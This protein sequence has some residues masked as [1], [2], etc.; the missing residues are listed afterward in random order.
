MNMIFLLAVS[1]G[2]SICTALAIYRLFFSPLA[3]IPGPK[4]AAITAWYEF[5]WDCVQQGHYLFKIGQMHQKY[6]PIVRINPW[7]VHIQDPSY[8]DTIYTNNKIDKDAWFYR[9][10]GDNRGTVGTGPWDLHRRR[11]AAMAKFFSA[12]NVARLEPKV[13]AR[14]QKLLD[15]VEEGRQCLRSGDFAVLPISHAF[16]CF[17][18]DVISDYAAPHTRDFLS[19]PDFSATFNQVLRDFS[20]IMLWHRHFPVV[21]P[22]LGAMPRWLISMMDPTGAQIAVLDNQASLLKQAQ[23][24]IATKGNPPEKSLPTVLD[25]I[26]TSDVIG[27]EEKTLPRMMAET[28]ALLG[29]GTETTGN[30]LSNFVYHVLSNKSILDKLMTELEEA[31]PKSQSSDLLDSRTLEKLPYLQAC[32]RE[33]LRLGMGVVGRLPRINPIAPM[34]Y[35]TP[36]PSESTPPKTY[37]FPPGTVLSMSII[38]MHLNSD[39]FPDPR[40]FRPERWIDSPEPHLRQMEK[41]FVPFGKGTRGCLGIELAKE[42]LTLMTGNL[43]RR[44]GRHMELFGTSGRD[45]SIVHDY[46]A[47]FGP[48]DSKGVR[49]VVR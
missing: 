39:I 12:A 15:R 8:W 32:I 26:Y 45:V 42:E 37:T 7:E 10:F 30:T 49:V 19:T 20:E 25:A 34:T 46:F 16:R 31:S 38:D 24:V 48:K 3:G 28:Q 44:F 9:A 36:S 22:I 41:C 29:A 6:G 5:Y 1:I 35:A 13:L 2:I 43:F 18:T 4:I 21:F 17:A 40:T 14:V 11:R 23:T 47:P 27:P 33:A